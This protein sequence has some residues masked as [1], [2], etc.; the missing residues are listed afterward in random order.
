M[1]GGIHTGR[2]GDPSAR[3]WTRVTDGGADGGARGDLLRP[4]IPS[5]GAACRMPPLCINGRHVWCVE[6]CV[7]RGAWCQDGTYTMYGVHSTH[8]RSYAVFLLDSP[9]MCG[10][11]CMV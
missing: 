2:G 1:G 8:G 10:T 4:R 5:K 11:V 3:A 9:G 7:V 6:A